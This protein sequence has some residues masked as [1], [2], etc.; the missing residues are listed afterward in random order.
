MGGLNFIKFK[1]QCSSPWHQYRSILRPFDRH[2]SY[3]THVHT[4]MAQSESSNAVLED[5]SKEYAR[6]FR[7]VNYIVNVC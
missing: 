4:A 3:R 6:S 2:S 1:F 7:G 5:I